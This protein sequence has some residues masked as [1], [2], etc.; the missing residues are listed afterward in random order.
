MAAGLLFLWTPNSGSVCASY[1]FTG[2]WGSFPPTVLSALMWGLLPCL[3]VSYFVCLSV[4]SCRPVLFWRGNE[5]EWIR[6]G[7]SPEKLGGVEGGEIMVGM[8]C[9]REESIF[10]K[11]KI[12][13]L[14]Y[15]VNIIKGIKHKPLILYTNVCGVYSGNSQTATQTS[16]LLFPV[17]TWPRW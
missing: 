16:M 11:N 14:L 17:A 4:V 15:I 9:K 12:E 3:T 5:G 10:N 2:S 13:L 8:Y 1:S 7:N 6:E